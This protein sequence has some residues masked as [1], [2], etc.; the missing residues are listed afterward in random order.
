[1]IRS[2]PLRD[3][4]RRAMC[5]VL[6]ALAAI[7]AL[8]VRGAWGQDSLHLETVTQDVTLRPGWNAVYIHV[9]APLQQ[10]VRMLRMARANA[11]GARTPVGISTPPFQVSS[12]LDTPE[13]P[14]D[15]LWAIRELD[16]TDPEEVEATAKALVPGRC[17]LIQAGAPQVNVSLQGAPS[18]RRQIW[19]GMAG[20]L[21]S[22]RV[23]GDE[24]P[25]LSEFFTTSDVLDGGIVYALTSNEGWRRIAD[26]DART[27]TPGDCFFIR[28]PR[29]T[30]FQGAA[31]AWVSGSDAVSFN[32]EAT[33][34]LLRLHNR[35]RSPAHFALSSPGFPDESGASP[36]P[37]LFVWNAE[38]SAREAGD[39]DPMVAADI[40]WEPLPPDG[41]PLTRVV[42]ARGVLDLR[43]GANMPAA[44]RWARSEGAEDDTRI[45]SVLRV[46][47]EGS[48]TLLPVTFDVPTAQPELTGLWVGDAAITHV[49]RI[50]PSA[51]D[52][53]PV[54]RPFLM[55]LIVLKQSDGSCSLLSDAI[56]LEEDAGAKRVL[57][58]DEAM[59]KSL[60]RGGATPVRR[61]RSVAYVTRAPLREDL[62][63]DPPSERPN[64]LER[65]SE[66]SFTLV[67]D[68]DDVLNP[69]LHVAHPD[70]DGLDERYENYLPANVESRRFERNLR[71][72]VGAADDERRFRSDWVATEIVGTVQETITGMINRP[73]ETSGV[74][75]LRRLT[76]ATL[77]EPRAG[78]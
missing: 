36:R 55:R 60:A 75:V 9:E 49:G 66:V 61:F 71:L 35:S 64:C 62:S 24:R 48:T 18:A 28:T 51:T 45:D 65:G 46:K 68:H 10:R 59:A 8:T 76:E 15:P 1:M 43:I 70:H 14:D 77:A 29:Y 11:I 2:D 7:V 4:G 42:P 19:Y 31:E 26:T 20:A 25:S 34:R 41:G 6:S 33:R 5:F 69:D 56:E 50:A 38:K 72:V 27:V 12:A 23:L 16:P 63:T 44:V 13:W 74:F 22:P 67:L 17:H 37:A 3:L 40:G 47:V 73:V 58:T 57:A 39:A 30:D 53:E 21:F 32:A 54:T 52:V 78:E